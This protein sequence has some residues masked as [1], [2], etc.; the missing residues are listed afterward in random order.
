MEFGVP[1]RAISSNFK[2]ARVNLI[3]LIYSNYFGL[4]LKLDSANVYGVRRTEND[5]FLLLDDLSPEQ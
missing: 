2:S 3:G 1:E 4:D 5:I